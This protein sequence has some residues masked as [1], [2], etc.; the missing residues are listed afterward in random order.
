MQLQNKFIALFIIIFGRLSFSIS[1]N[2]NRH[3][4]VASAVVSSRLMLRSCTELSSSDGPAAARVKRPSDG[5]S[6]GQPISAR[7]PVEQIASQPIGGRRRCLDT[8]R[9]VDTTRTCSAALET[10]LSLHG[11]LAI[12]TTSEHSLVN[13][14]T[15]RVQAPSLDSIAR[16]LSRHLTDMSASAP[17][18]SRKQFAESDTRDSEQ[19]ASCSGNPLLWPIYRVR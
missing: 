6:S 4:L 16:R 9:W 11:A 1:V 18:S 7:A 13:P 2:F 19:V 14:P 12:M 15:R 8:G 3:F 5:I 10:R 17:I